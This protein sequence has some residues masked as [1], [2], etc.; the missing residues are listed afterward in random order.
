MNTTNEQTP[1]QAPIEPGELSRPVPR[2][3]QLRL[4]ELLKKELVRNDLTIIEQ[5]Y[6]WDS[7]FTLE[8]EL[9]LPLDPDSPIPYSVA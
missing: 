5:E 7:L 1:H 9:F 4:Y 3:Q 2:L 8:R 6:L